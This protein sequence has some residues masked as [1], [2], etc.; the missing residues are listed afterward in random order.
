MIVGWKQQTRKR[1]LENSEGAI[2]CGDTPN[3][4]QDMRAASST[5]VEQLISFSFIE[6]ATGHQTNSVSICWVLMFI[7]ISPADIYTQAGVITHTQ[8]AAL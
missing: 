1:E 6:R 3:V 5:P 4:G 8:T 2:T 7:P